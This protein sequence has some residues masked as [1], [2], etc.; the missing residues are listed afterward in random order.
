MNADRLS[1]IVE[2]HAPEL[3]MTP[4]VQQEADFNV[5]ARK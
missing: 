3:R 1:R 5:E 4:K 2:C